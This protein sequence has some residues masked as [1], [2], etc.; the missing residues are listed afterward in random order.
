ME[1]PL[2]GINHYR[3]CYTYC[4]GHNKVVNCFENDSI[5]SSVKCSPDGEK[6]A[7]GD[8]KSILNICDLRSDKKCGSK[9]LIA[10]KICSLDW[11][12][13][14]EVTA[15]NTRAIT[16]V[17]L[18]TGVAAWMIQANSNLVC[19]LKWDETKSKLATGNDFNTV[20]IFDIAK[21]AEK[22]LFH[23]SHQGSVRA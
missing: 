22:N 7:F 6:I 19:S 9:D 14:F 8:E 5:L 12:T 21:T 11:R 13:P 2:V 16:H 10:S 17:D 4:Y 18:R 3:E 23:Y 20:R 15:G 1:R